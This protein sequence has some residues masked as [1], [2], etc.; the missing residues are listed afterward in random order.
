MWVSLLLH[1]VF[2]PSFFSHDFL[3]VCFPPFVFFSLT[4]SYFLS[5][6]PV[7]TGLLPTRLAAFS[8][9]FHLSLRLECYLLCTKH[10]RLFVSYRQNWCVDCHALLD[11]FP[12]RNSI[13]LHCILP[14]RS[15]VTAWQCFSLQS[16]S[17]VDLFFPF[18]LFRVRIY[19]CF[20]SVASFY[21]LTAEKMKTTK[22]KI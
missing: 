9:C 13:S 19:F 20:P 7:I 1:I 15:R 21:K 2:I 5:Y 3:P 17:L 12:T 16:T 10:Q 11:W 18:F 6:F 14:L 22:D 8:F 4:S